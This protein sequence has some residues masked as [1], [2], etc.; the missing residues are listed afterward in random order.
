MADTIFLQK[1]G[2]AIA[3]GAFRGLVGW[4]LEQ[5]MDAIKTTWQVNRGLPSVI[6]VVKNI[7][8]RDGFLGFFKGGLPNAIR[9]TSKQVYRF[10]PLLLIPEWYRQH[11]PKKIRNNRFFEAG[12]TG[13][14][15]AQLETI[16]VTPTERLKVWRM[17]NT[18]PRYNRLLDFAVQQKG[19]VMAGLYQGWR[20]TFY[21]V[22]ASWLSFLLANSACKQLIYST[23]EPNGT[24]SSALFFVASFPVAAVNTLAVMPFDVAKSVIQRAGAQN[25]KHTFQLMKELIR[26]EGLATVFTGWKIK[27]AHSLMQALIT[28]PLL[29]GVERRWEKKRV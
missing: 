29:E 15:L 8:G 26:K 12:V 10:P 11:A 27:F 20:P 14:A 21:K 5:P 9:L 4:P 23:A 13:I 18:D 17:T 25:T 1:F 28:V 6:S 2:E 16:I 19:Q 22:S 3:I 24:P 7:Y